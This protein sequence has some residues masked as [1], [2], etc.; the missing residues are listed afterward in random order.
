MLIIWAAKW[1]RVPYA[2]PLV[3]D[4]CRVEASVLPEMV[5]VYRVM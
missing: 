3:A 5:P 2:L 1:Y 4:R